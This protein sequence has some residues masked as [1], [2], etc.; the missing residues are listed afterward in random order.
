MNL[1]I[2]VL[3]IGYLIFDLCVF[4]LICKK[5]K[6][7]FNSYTVETANELIIRYIPFL[8]N[9]GI[10]LTNYKKSLYIFLFIL[11]SSTLCKMGGY[12]FGFKLFF[13]YI[14]LKNQLY[15]SVCKYKMMRKIAILFCIVTFI[16]LGVNGVGV[17]E[18]IFNSRNAYM[19]GRTGNGIY[20]VLFQ[21]SLIVIAV[22]LLCEKNYYKKSLYKYWLVIL[23]SVL[24]GSKNM[25]LGIILIY[26][27]YRDMFVKKMSIKKV[28]FIGIAGLISIMMLLKIQSNITL[29]DYSDY[30]SNFIRLLDYSMNDEWNFYKGKITIENLLW[31][32]IP[33]SL[34]SNKPYIYG[35]SKIINLFYPENVILAGNTPSFSQYCIS[36]A[37][38]GVSGICLSF[39]IKGIFRG[40]L[41][42]NLR[43][44]MK[45]Y[46]ISF[47]IYFTYC[48][49]FIVTPLNFGIIYFILF[50]TLIYFMQK[51]LLNL[52]F[53]INKGE[54]V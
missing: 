11:Y 5:N 52:K 43:K 19:T 36:Y 41:E 21:L 44:N 9:L 27:F 14:R 53:T 50:Y 32:M 8:L 40:F 28:V 25:I 7:M 1:L 15:Y 18:W 30:Y 51:Y 10:Y 39:F 13:P 48:V 42:N 6:S 54:R 33:R 22:L 46:G 34:Y 12:L 23:G 16:L 4:L 24:T 26:F 20:Y 49:C 31:G 37:D 45:F 2:V 3:S 35:Y 38:F 29:A 47:N 17:K